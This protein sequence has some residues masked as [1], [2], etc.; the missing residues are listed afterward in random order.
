MRVEHMTFLLHQ[1]DATVLQGVRTRKHSLV[2]CVE[3]HATQGDGGEFVPVNAPGQFC[4]SC[5]SFASV[6]LD[7]FECHAARPVG[8]SHTQ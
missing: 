1:R 2:G 7:C 4:Q 3:C 6:K 8:M 5:H